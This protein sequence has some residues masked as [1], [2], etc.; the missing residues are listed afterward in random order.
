MGNE[1]EDKLKEL[2]YQENEMLNKGDWEKFDEL[3]S[4]DY[5][6]PYLGFKGRKGVKQQFIEAKKAFPD[7]TFT[8]E[9]TIVQGNVIVTRLTITGTHHGE[10]MG[11]APT[12]RTFKVMA[13][14]IDRTE[15]GKFV[16]RWA[17]FDFYSELIQLGVKEVPKGL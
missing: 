12:G 1:R 14:S 9:D 16:E 15:G 8:I 7:L 13:L 3:Y 2:I 11:I 10:F 4:E 17:L 5:I 6:E